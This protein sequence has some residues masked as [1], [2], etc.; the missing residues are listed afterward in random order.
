MQDFVSLWIIIKIRVKK[1]MRKW[2]VWL[3]TVL[4]VCGCSEGYDDS[5][6]NLMPS[7]DNDAVSSMSAFGKNYTVSGTTQLASVTS[8][9]VYLTIDNAAMSLRLNVM[10]DFT[11][12][13][14][15]EGR[16]EL[17]DLLPD[18]DNPV[19]APTPFV[20]MFRE[21]GYSE[22]VVLYQIPTSVYR[23]Q[24]RTGDEIS[25]TFSPDSE[26]V[27]NLRT[28]AIMLWLYIQDISKNGQKTT[29]YQQ[30]N[31]FKDG[32]WSVMTFQSGNIF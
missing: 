7:L 30:L 24:L 17:I 29:N 19:V 15:A 2:Y 16:Q 18:L 23:F 3:F 27:V 25:V 13:L 21:K 26:L 1:T 10:P 4:V 20:T 11:F 14:M 6:R 9:G 8:S 28:G 12:W 22:D 5:I 31:Y 32:D